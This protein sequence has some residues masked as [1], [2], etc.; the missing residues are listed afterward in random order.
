[1]SQVRPFSKQMCYCPSN[2]NDMSLGSLAT[3]DLITAANQGL[4]LLSGA[5]TLYNFIQGRRRKRKKRR[6]RFDQ[7]FEWTECYI[8]SLGRTIKHFVFQQIRIDYQPEKRF[9]DWSCQMFRCI[10]KIGAK[11]FYFDFLQVSMWWISLT[12]KQTFMWGYIK[13]KVKNRLC[14]KSEIFCQSSSIQVT[15][16]YQSIFCSQIWKSRLTLPRAQVV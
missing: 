10:F 3:P 11:L 12:L 4:G 9:C 5:I 7:N 2:R 8:P 6:K 14:E 15:S 16:M 13:G 1:M